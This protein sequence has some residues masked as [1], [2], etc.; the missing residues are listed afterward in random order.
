MPCSVLG[1][2]SCIKIYLRKGEITSVYDHPLCI[3]PS[4]NTKK[5]TNKPPKKERN[6]DTTH[7]QSYAFL[8][9][10]QHVLVKYAFLCHWISSQRHVCSVRFVTAPVSFGTCNRYSDVILG[11]YTLN[12]KTF[13]NTIVLEWY[14][15]ITPAQDICIWPVALNFR[16]YL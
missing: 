12:C 3:Y 5:N 1:E 6:S 14:P 2:C 16:F 11:A 15:C 4:R 7:T 9:R 10:T 8:S 13:T